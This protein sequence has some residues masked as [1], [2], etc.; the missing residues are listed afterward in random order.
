MTRTNVDLDDELVQRVMR[1]Y[2]VRTKREAVDL[3][4]RRLVEEPMSTDEAL[5]MEGSGWGDDELAVSDLRDRE[6]PAQL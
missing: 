3:A 2:N 4:L 5:A 6:P 1:L